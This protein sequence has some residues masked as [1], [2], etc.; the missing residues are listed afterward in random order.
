M[1]HTALMSYKCAVVDV[2]FGGAKGGVKIDPRNYTPE[3]LER[4]T[5]RYT[6]ELC[7]KNFIGPGIDVPAPDAGTGPQTM[8]WVLDTYR[9]VRFLFVCLC[10]GKLTLDLTAEPGRHQRIC[11]RHRQAP[12]PRR[13]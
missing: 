1:R 13:C 9:M 7:Q 4:I 11:C 3:E 8:A 12:V 2:P 6:M 10:L 5:R